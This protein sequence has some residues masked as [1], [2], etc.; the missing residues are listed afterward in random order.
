M[1]SNQKVTSEENE[2]EGAPKNEKKDG[3]KSF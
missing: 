1:V 3:M 2:S